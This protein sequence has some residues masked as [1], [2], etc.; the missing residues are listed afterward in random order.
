MQ[1]LYK[2]ESQSKE[3]ADINEKNLRIILIAKNKYLY[4]VQK[5]DPIRG[6][7]RYYIR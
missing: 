3:P 5:P 4:F 1:T 7:S 6:I 2:P